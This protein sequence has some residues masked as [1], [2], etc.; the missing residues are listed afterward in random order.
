MD[1]ESGKLIGN[2]D[3]GACNADG[4][5]FCVADGSDIKK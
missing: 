5:D 3:F 4:E 1:Y 2:G